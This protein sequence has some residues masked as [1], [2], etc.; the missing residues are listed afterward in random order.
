MTTMHLKTRVDSSG[1]VVVD[2]G[3][4]EAGREVLVSIAPNE[5]HDRP[6]VTQDEWIRVITKTAGSIDDP[7]FVRP[8][9]G[10]IDPP[11]NFDEPLDNG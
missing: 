8:D 6:A 10:Y 11:P 3:E 4:S 7:A 1:K 2:V 9:L 5:S